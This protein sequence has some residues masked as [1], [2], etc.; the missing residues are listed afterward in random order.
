MQNTLK[1]QLKYTNLEGEAIHINLVSQINIIFSLKMKDVRSM[2]LNQVF[3]AIERK[4]LG[5][6]VF[7]LFVF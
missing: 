2:S 6:V 5:L 1:E 7:C 4:E 3:M